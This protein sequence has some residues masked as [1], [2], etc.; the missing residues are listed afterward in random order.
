MDVAQLLVSD[1]NLNLS[2][3][4]SLP[5]NPVAWCPTHSLSL[6]LVSHLTPLDP[7]A[8]SGPHRSWNPLP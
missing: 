3:D 6:A 8:V 1:S 2:F 7:L 4:G 5:A